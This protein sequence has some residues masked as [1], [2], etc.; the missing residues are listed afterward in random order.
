[1][2]LPIIDINKKGWYRW[3]LKE[4]RVAVGILIHQPCSFNESGIVGVTQN[5][6]TIEHNTNSQADAI[7][8]QYYGYNG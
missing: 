8:G 4:F 1:M 5:G 6:V 7:L 2:N 3:Q